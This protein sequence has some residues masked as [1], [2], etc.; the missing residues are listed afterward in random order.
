MGLTVTIMAPGLSNHSR[1]FADEG[2]PTNATMLL[3]RTQ[4]IGRHLCD[5]LDPE[6]T[7]CVIM[8]D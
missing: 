4:G 5:S 8:C 6:I 7:A 2:L 3:K 1:F